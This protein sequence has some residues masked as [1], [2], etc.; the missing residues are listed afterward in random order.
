MPSAASSTASP[1]ASETAGGEDAEFEAFWQAAQG[2][3]LVPLYQRIFSD[4]L[5][6]V[7]AYRCLVKDSDVDAPSYLLESVVNGNQQGRYS[8]VGACPAMEVVASQNTV[9]VL[10]HAAG[11]RTT[12]SVEDPMEVGAPASAPVPARGWGAGEGLGEAESRSGGGRRCA[13]A[14]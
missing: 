9:T 3:N 8:F 1:T 6:P 5:T 14:V 2:S 11:T 12:S 13:C 10:D 4:Q 7:L